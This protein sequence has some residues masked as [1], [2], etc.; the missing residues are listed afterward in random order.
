M[1]QACGCASQRDKP[2]MFG[3]APEKKGYKIKLEKGTVLPEVRRN[4]SR[5]LEFKKF[6]G[7]HREEDISKLYSFDKE[8]GAGQ[9]GKVYLATNLQFKEQCAVKVIQ[10]TRI[11]ERE[12]YST[13]MK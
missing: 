12:I 1:G 3:Q 5:F 8:L 6:K 10:K 13:L 11:N 9:F 2:E 4:N 7:F